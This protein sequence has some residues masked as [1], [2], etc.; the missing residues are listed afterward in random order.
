[1]SRLRP[2][3]VE[4]LVARYQAGDTVYELAA[5]FHVNRK[6]VSR[7]LHHEGVSMRMKG[8]TAEQIVEAERLYRAGWPLSRI[9]Q[10]MQVDTRTVHR[11]LKERGVLGVT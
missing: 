4:A 2:D 8:L 5:R 9:G 11:R 3:Q 7:T 6:T 10:L 1:M